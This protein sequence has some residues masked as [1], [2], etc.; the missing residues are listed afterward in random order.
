MAALPSLPTD[1]GVV[2]G[3]QAGLAKWRSA[4][5]QY[6]PGPAGAM[7]SSYPISECAG[8]TAPSAPPTFLSIHTRILHLLTS[9]SYL[10]A[11]RTT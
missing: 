5:G 10:R 9:I 6:V 1:I 8:A 7:R 11:V 4:L 2:G 3:F